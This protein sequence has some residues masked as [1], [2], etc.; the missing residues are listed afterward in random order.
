MCRVLSANELSLV[1]LDSAGLAARSPG[2]TLKPIQLVASVG[3]HDVLSHLGIERPALP[4]VCDSEQ[5]PKFC[6]AHLALP[7][8]RMKHAPG[9]SPHLLEAVFYERMGAFKLSGKWSTDRCMM[10]ASCMQ[11]CAT[12]SKKMCSHACANQLTGRRGPWE[13]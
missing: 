9:G 10:Q 7:S 13:V 4:F 3:R 12:S 1:G 11:P 2:W 8:T 6:E 5:W